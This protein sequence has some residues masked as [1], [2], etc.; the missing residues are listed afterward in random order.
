MKKAN[1]I[2][3]SIRYIHNQCGNARSENRIIAIDTYVERSCAY[4]YACVRLIF[5]RKRD[6]YLPDWKGRVFSLFVFKKVIRRKLKK[7]KKEKRN[8]EEIKKNI[9]TRE[10]GEID[11][12]KISTKILEIYLSNRSVEKK[13]E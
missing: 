3:F 8:E 11:R 9:K 10:I 2:K 13:N 5:Q 6:S 12:R 1:G 4:V 7:L